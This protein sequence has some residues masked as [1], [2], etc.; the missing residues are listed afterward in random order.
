MHAKQI[1][2]HN[3]AATAILTEESEENAHGGWMDE[4]MDGTHGN[5]FTFSV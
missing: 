1:Y 3:L 4:W 2:Q 5:C